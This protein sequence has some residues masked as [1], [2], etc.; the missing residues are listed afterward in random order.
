MCRDLHNI[1]IASTDKDASVLK[2]LLIGDLYPQRTVLSTDLPGLEFD[3]LMH[4]KYGKSYSCAYGCCGRVNKE[5]VRETAYL[6]RSYIW[7]LPL[8][9]VYLNTFNS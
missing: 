4:N 6:G 7:K 3:D 9:A 5:R 2:C 1:V 8:A